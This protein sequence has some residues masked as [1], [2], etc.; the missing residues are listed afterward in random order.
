MKVFEMMEMLSLL[1]AFARP[2]PSQRVK[3]IVISD[4]I[5]AIDYE[6]SIMNFGDCWETLAVTNKVD[7]SVC[8]ALAAHLYLHLGVRDLSASSR[9]YLMLFEGRI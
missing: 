7:L 8:L 3:R 4:S 2:Y 1:T 6:L 5:Y 9:T